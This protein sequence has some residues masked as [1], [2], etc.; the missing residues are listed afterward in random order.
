MSAERQI[1]LGDQIHD[2]APLT[3][4]QLRTIGPRLPRCVDWTN[5]RYDDFR[6]FVEGS[7]QGL[8]D[9]AEIIAAATGMTIDE[10]EAIAATQMQAAEAVIKIGTLAGVVKAK[11]PD[12]MG[13]DRAETST[14]A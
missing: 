13:E 14:G 3:L 8:G 7:D 9:A 1:V 10:I 6:A 2:F 5:L 11:E 12:Q 4:K